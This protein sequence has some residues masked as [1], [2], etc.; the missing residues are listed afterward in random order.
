MSI[1]YKGKLI[2]LLDGAHG[3]SCFIP[4]VQQSLYLPL[5]LVGLP[6]IGDFVIGPQTGTLFIL[7]I[8]GID[9]VIVGHQL[10]TIIDKF[11]QKSSL[12]F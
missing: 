3:L 8:E 7:G 4:S 11:N 5:S 2:I 10:L 6:V 1:L 9:E 12:V